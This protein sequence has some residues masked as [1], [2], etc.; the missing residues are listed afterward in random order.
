MKIR[1]EETEDNNEN[2]EEC[3]VVE[4]VGIGGGVV[5]VERAFKGAPSES[6]FAAC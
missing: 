4:L 5:G 2:G 6:E 3:W 1:S